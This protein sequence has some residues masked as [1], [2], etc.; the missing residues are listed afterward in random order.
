MNLTDIR[1]G[2]R[3]VCVMRALEEA[4]GEGVVSGEIHGEMHLAIGQELVSAVMKNHLTRPDVVVSTHRAH[5]HALASGVN[6][7]SLLAELFERDGLNHGK[8]GHMHLFDSDNGFMCSGIV[9]SGAP[10]AAGYALYQKVRATG[11]I[12]VAAVGDGAMNQGAVF[13]TMNLA[14]VR[15][16]PLVFLCE[17]NQYGISVH[18]DASTAG[19]LVK[20]GD[21]LGIPGYRCDGTD[22]LAVDSAISEAFKFTRNE[23]R[24]SL[25]VARV[26]RFRGHYE[27]DTDLY[28]SEEEKERSRQEMDPITEMETLMRERGIADQ[29]IG[30]IKS[31][32]GHQVAEWIRQARGFP[33]PDPASALTGVFVNE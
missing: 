33:Q 24:P 3:E 8:G 23:S 2:Y 20:R 28:R 1:D 32:A 27:G 11:G 6:P 22:M 29:D 9:G 15:N 16:L 14:A 17:D 18:R 4:V 7:V 12:T 31:D 21:P 10:L 30:Q 19:D 5:L 13:E 25:V 26:Y